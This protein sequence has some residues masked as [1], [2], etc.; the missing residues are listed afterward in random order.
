LVLTEKGGAQGGGAQVSALGLQ[1]L[2]AY[3]GLMR[4]LARSGRKELDFLQSHL[5]KGRAKKT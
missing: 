3:R 4:K 1:V 5:R 2:A